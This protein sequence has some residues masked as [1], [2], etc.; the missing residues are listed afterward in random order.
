VHCRTLNSRAGSP[1]FHPREKPPEGGEE[2]KMKRLLGT[3]VVLSVLLFVF[4]MGVHAAP[5]TYLDQDNNKG[6]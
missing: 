6:M 4:A 5:S 2:K 3:L 1:V